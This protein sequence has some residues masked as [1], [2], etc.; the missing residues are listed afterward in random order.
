MAEVNS[1]ALVLIWTCDDWRVCESTILVNGAGGT[2]SLVSSECMEI[3]YDSFG[4][5]FSCCILTWSFG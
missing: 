2:R 4:V 5:N 1:D 3:E